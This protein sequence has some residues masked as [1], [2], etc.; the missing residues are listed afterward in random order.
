[1]G[2]LYLAGALLAGVSK[3]YCGKRASGLIRGYQDSILLNLIRM[4]FCIVISLGVLIAE[5]FDKLFLSPNTVPILLLGGVANGLFLINWLLA[6][7]SSAYLL[8]D[9]A[10]TFSIILP[11][12]GAV[13][14]LKEP[15]KP[16]QLWG[17][18]ILF[19]AMLLMYRY[20]KTV[21][22]VPDKRTLAALIICA[23]GSG[24]ADFSQK[25]YAVRVPDGGASAYQ[26]FIYLITLLMLLAYLLVL[27]QKA[28]DRTSAQPL[29]KNGLHL[30]FLMALFHFGHSFLKLRAA[31][32]IP[33]AE[34]Y[35][36]L[37][38]GS[39]LLSTLMARLLF[40]EPLKVTTL[41][42]LLLTFFGF[43]IIKNC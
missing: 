31:A 27:K 26:F 36:L 2:Y 21:K 23:L 30:I 43:M 29:L 18:L 4:A 28:A 6:V 41:L 8:V 11:I 25:L 22:G 20:N 1:M 7:R 39:L 34:L 3:G 19:C 35:P 42:S 40:K 9:T 16:G 17:L 33:A 24:F 12:A 10:L 13:F 37:Q 5:G 15:I 32:L 14:F 38:G